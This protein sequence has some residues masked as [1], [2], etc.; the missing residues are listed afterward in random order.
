M[1]K[2]IGGQQ[3]VFARP[4]ARPDPRTSRANRQRLRRRAR[5]IAGILRQQAGDEAG[6]QVAAA[7]FGHAGIAG[8]VYGDAAVGMRDERACAFEHQRDAHALG[9]VARRLEPVR[10]HFGDRDSGQPRH[11]AGMRRE[12]ERALRFAGQFGQQDRLGGENVER[13]GVDDRRNLEWTKAIRS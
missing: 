8:G 4:R 7:A 5:N 2:A 10:L 6:E 11:F 3:G 12:D 9:K 1:R 13:V